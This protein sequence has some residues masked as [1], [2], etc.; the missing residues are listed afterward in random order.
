MTSDATHPNCRAYRAFGLEPSE[1]YVEA[2]QK[3]R[4][5]LQPC[6]EYTRPDATRGAM[7][8]MTW[9]G[10]FVRVGDDG[11]KR[12]RLLDEHAD[13]ENHMRQAQQKGPPSKKERSGY[14][15]RADTKAAIRQC[16]HLGA[17]LPAWRKG[18]RRVLDTVRRALE[19]E[20]Q[21]LRAAVPS[22][23]TAKQV[24][25]HTNVA[26]LCAIVDS[27]KLPDYEMPVNFVRGFPSVG[28]IPDSGMFREEEPELSAEEFGQ[29]FNSIDATNAEW[30]EEVCDLLRVRAVRAT[31]PAREALRDL[32][33]RTEKEVAS[34]LLAPAMTRAQL[35]DKYLR[36]GRLQARVLP[37]CGIMQKSVTWGCGVRACPSTSQVRPG[38]AVHQRRRDP[39]GLH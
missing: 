28:E 16:A 30:L 31:G 26:L 7:R 18:Q 11:I 1:R 27:A 25:R 8:D 12:G 34:G 38:P 13:K 21:V 15:L 9:R 39:L 6:E 37:R 24:A 2:V 14:T 3:L 4:A 17:K 19:P 5:A 23:S 32:Q 36:D 33:A 35:L 29:L 22:A 10:P 20:N